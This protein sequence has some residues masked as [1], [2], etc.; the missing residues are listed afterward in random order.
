MNTEELWE[1][2]LDPNKRVLLR[3]TLQE[4]GEA[5]RMF[6][7]LMG[8]DVE[9]DAVHRGSCAGSEEP[10][11]VRIG[12]HVKT[13][14]TQYSRNDRESFDGKHRF[15]HWYVDNQVYFITAR[16]R[17]QFHAFATEQAKQIFW[18]RFGF[19]CKEFQFTPWITSL[20]DN[21]YHTLGYLKIGM[22]LKLTMQRI[23]GSVAKFVNDLFP[24]R[25]QDFWRDSKGREYFDGCLRDEKQGRLTYRYIHTQS[26]RH[27]VMKDYLN[28][29]HTRIHVEIER[30][31][32]R[33]NELGAFL[34][35]CLTSGMNNKRHSPLKGT[36]VFYLSTLAYH[37]SVAFN[38]GARATIGSYPSTFLIRD[39]SACE[40][41]T[42]PARSW[43]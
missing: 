37:S 43:A 25:R 17:D 41:R 29:P 3:V 20:L 11:R 38:P 7:V 18:D 13:D 35:T 30:A 14:S 27:G 1:T 36:R 9:R 10:G 15:E 31:I 21:H 32:K 5:E 33:A 16:C 34:R 8:E 40:W 12:L 23:H 19:Y 26:R 2:T 24:Q 22:N 39:K 28:Y 42:S 6:S 4:A